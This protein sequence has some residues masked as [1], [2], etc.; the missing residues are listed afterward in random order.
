MFIFGSPPARRCRADTSLFIPLHDGYLAVNVLYLGVILCD[1]L[2]DFLD[3]V[4][5]DVIVV[6]HHDD[7]ALWNQ[8]NALNLVVVEQK[9]LIVHFSQF[10]HRAALPCPIPPRR[11]AWG[12]SAIPFLSASC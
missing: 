1:L 5:Y 4:P 2:D 9:T 8:L 3:R 10:N 6:I 7:F 12:R 11:Q